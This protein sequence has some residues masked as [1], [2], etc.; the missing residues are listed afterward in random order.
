MN[1]P[2]SHLRSSSH[3]RSRRGL[4][5]LLVILALIFVTGMIGVTLRQL[6]AVNRQRRLVNYRA[7][8]S[9]LADSGIE[10]AVSMA[11]RDPDYVA[12]TWT[13][14]AGEM[15]SW[16][17]AEVEISVDRSS[18]PPRIVV[19]AHYPAQSK[20]QAHVRK[21]IQARVR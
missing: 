8:A 15:G 2:Q 6:N 3:H 13:I 4:S 20:V 14:T 16:H 5:T 10:R 21:Q 9:L 18:L 11:Q 17:G 19:A 1:R 7:Q 12:E